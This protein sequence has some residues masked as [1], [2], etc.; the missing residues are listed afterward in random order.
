MR[1][2]PWEQLVQMT[3]LQTCVSIPY[4]TDERE[5]E[6]WVLSPSGGKNQARALVT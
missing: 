5:V 6:T 4:G 3:V 1:T 2:Q